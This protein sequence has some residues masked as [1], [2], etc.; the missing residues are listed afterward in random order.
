M[1]LHIYGWGFIR[2]T[3]RLWS[4]Q[5]NDYCLLMESLRISSC[6]LHESGCLNIPNLV[7]ENW[8]IPRELMGFSLLWNLEE[9]DCNSSE[10]MS[11]Q[12]DG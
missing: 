8:E 9:K 5:F 12:Q 10:G 6:P 2:A 11:W 7:S 1:C 3:H 4:R